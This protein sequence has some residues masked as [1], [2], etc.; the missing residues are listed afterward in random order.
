VGLSARS[1]ITHVHATPG[2]VARR[3]LFDRL[4]DAQRVMVICAPAGSGKTSVLR[5]WIAEMGLDE[6]AAW[7]AVEREEEDPQRFW[8]SVIRG[9]RGTSAGSGAIEAITPNPEL[10]AEA[11]VERLLADLTAIEDPVWLVLDD[12]HELRSSEALRQLKLLLMRSPAALRFVLIT[13]RDLSLGLSRLRLEG[14]VTEVRAEDL[15][16]SL[17]EA[18]ALFESSGVPVADSALALLHE[19][20]EGWA[21]GL[22]MAALSLARHP[23]HDRFAAE[24]SG[25]ERSV[26]EYLLDEVLDQ[27]P[28]EVRSLLLRTSV[29]ERV[30]GALADRLTGGSDGDRILTELEQAGAFVVALDPQRSWF[31]YHQLFADLLAL[32]LRRT[33]SGE[34]PGLHAAAAQWFAEHG[35]PVDAIRHAQSA[36]NWGFAARLLADHWFGIFLDGDW[37]SARETL[38]AFPADAVAAYPE[39]E[40]V[41]AADELTDGSPGAAE[42]HLKLA[43]R[44]L[45]A[46]PEERREQFEVTRTALR[47]A[48]ARARNDLTAVAQGAQ[49]L[50]VPAESG[51]LIPPGL[52]E[53]LRALALMQL[54]IAEVWT[55]LTDEAEQHLEQTVALAR[56]INRPLLEL[57]ALAHLALAT[58]L[59]SMPLG[60]EHG[61]QAVELARANGWSEDPFTGTA[62]VVLGSLNLW[63]GR[64]PEAEHWLRRATSAMPGDVEVA[65]A[66][67]LMLHGTRALLALVRGLREEALA[68]FRAE[69]R[70]DALLAEHSPPSFVQAQMLVGQVLMGDTGPAENVLTSLDDT[71]RDALHMRVVL[72]TLCLARDQPEAAAA[73]LALMVDRPSGPNIDETTPPVIHLRWAIQALL[74]SAIALDT[75]RDPG[76]VSRALERALDLAEP[77]GLILPFL[78]FPTRELLERH[79]RLRTAHASLISEILDVRAGKAPTARSGQAPQLQEPLSDTELRVLRY[80]P[81]NLPAP[82]IASELVVSVN[83]IRTHT[84]HLYNKLGVHTR[85]QAV[86]RARELG[87]LAPT[88]RSR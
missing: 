15:R 84:H 37:A 53:Q 82:E 81:T 79:A 71:A 75:L 23:D 31:R 45:A 26:A 73:A 70:H 59:R 69:Q 63:R 47:L 21:A 34:L 3:E 62:Y 18:Q 17:D 39:L 51:A 7:V 27:L 40:L 43:A 49:E 72:A 48:V 58:Y 46:V 42:G 22:R 64:L 19:R 2:I 33:A 29:L 36:E 68:A 74:L 57:G 85:A 32:E 1:D 80:L 55:G 8:L 28:D 50:L 65:P 78:F 54:G 16:F 38:A 44:E 87:L 20:T 6:S 10:N 41:A 61:K 66:A 5:S 25:S 4:G 83:T 86:K 30:S 35:H 11:I 52:G 60:E 67:G 14:A 88:P 12:L 76:G 24:F 77:D 56:R 13:R 9:L